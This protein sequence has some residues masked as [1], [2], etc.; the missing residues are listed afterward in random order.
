MDNTNVLMY[1]L[2]LIE[3]ERIL[4]VTAIS[5]INSLYQL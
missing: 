2:L 5:I 1:I 4:R 3:I